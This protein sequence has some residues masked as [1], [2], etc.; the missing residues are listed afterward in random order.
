MQSILYKMNYLKVV[1]ASQFCVLGLETKGFWCGSGFPS[2][3]FLGNVDYLKKVLRCQNVHIS[4]GNSVP[5]REEIIISSP[6]FL[7]EKV[8]TKNRQCDKKEY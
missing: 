8:L 4:W 2:K 6:T 7:H 1:H 5:E 3:D